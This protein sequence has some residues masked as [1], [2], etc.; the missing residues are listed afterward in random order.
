MRYVFAVLL[1]LPLGACETASERAVRMEMEDDAACQRLS[2][3]KGPEAYT[4][5]RQNLMVYRQEVA[6]ED[7]VSRQ[8]AQAIGQSMQNAGAALSSIGR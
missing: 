6:R 7:E 8:R 1:V 4:A 2:A 5:C 3:G